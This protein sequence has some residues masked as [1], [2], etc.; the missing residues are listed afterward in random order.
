[1]TR[2]I[3]KGFHTL[4]PHIT[5]KDA[6]A[7]IEFYAKAFGA[8]ELRR[9]EMMGKVSHAD[10]QIGDSIVM[11]NDEFSEQGVSAPSGDGPG[12]RIN[13][14]VEDADAVFQR[15]VDAGVEVVFPLADMFWGD[16]YG[17]VKCPLGYH[18]SIATR[19]EDLSAE[20]IE[21]RSKQAFA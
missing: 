17:M 4:T 9:H 14:Y 16:R 7:A 13:I 19:K 3:P 21:E 5:V 1:M 15:A 12:F 18:W 11:L 20:E 8:K 2:P 10:V 6:P